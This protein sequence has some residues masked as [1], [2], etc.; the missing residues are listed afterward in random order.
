[1]RSLLRALTALAVAAFATLALAPTGLNPDASA[2][3]GG[4]GG[5]GGGGG[6]RG[7]GSGGGRGGGTGGG[8]GG[9]TGGGRG[10]GA[11]GGTGG[12]ARGGRNNTGKTGMGG[13]T[14]SDYL[15]ELQKEDA[16]A[17]RP[18]FLWE[19][20]DASLVR[21]GQDDREAALKAQR[22]EAARERRSDTESGFHPL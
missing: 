19:I 4:G 2:R 5:R 20:R 14:T 3:G 18:D 9:G 8:R 21:A 16:D 13:K 1:M 22:E 11:G 17:I 15:G 6:G 12:G 7:G 10:G